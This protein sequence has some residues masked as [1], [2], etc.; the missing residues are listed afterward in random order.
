MVGNT[1][2]KSL[3][4]VCGRWCIVILLLK[5]QNVNYLKQ[6]FGFYKIFK[7]TSVNSC[8]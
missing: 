2:V 8:A 6:L 1:V 7:G 3:Y 4:F 5:L